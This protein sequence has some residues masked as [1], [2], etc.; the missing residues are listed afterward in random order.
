MQGG[1]SRGAFPPAPTQYSHSVMTIVHLLIS[2]KRQYDAERA[3][4]YVNSDEGRAAA[5]ELNRLRAACEQAE[6]NY[7]ATCARCDAERKAEGVK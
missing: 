7:L 1:G 6:A 3:F 5:E 2:I 4:A